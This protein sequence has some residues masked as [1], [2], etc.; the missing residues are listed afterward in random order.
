MKTSTFK[1]VAAC[2]SVPGDHHTSTVAAQRNPAVTTYVI[3]AALARTD[4]ER[5]HSN[6][7]GELHAR[8]AAWARP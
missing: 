5:C 1:K 3:A 4:A 8:T 6:R 2:K 7:L